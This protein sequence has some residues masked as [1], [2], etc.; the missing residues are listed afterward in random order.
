M[1]V[2]R[3]HKR[4]SSLKKKKGSR[5]LSRKRSRRVRSKSMAD[6]GRVSRKL[7]RKKTRRH[8]RRAKTYHMKGGTKQNLDFKYGLASMIIEDKSYTGDLRRPERQDSV[9][10]YYLFTNDTGST[11][12]INYDIHIISQEDCQ[13]FSILTDILHKNINMNFNAFLKNINYDDEKGFKYN[14]DNK[15]KIDKYTLKPFNVTC[16]FGG[17]NIGKLEITYKHIYKN[18]LTQPNIYKKEDVII[19][20]PR[21]TS[22]IDHDDHFKFD[23]TPYSLTKFKVE[24][25]T[26]FNYL[27]KIKNNLGVGKSNP[28]KFFDTHKIYVY[29]FNED[30]VYDS[31]Y[32]NF[33]REITG[34]VTGKAIE[35]T[36]S[37]R[38]ITKEKYKQL[39]IEEV[40]NFKKVMMFY[41][42]L[43]HFITNISNDPYN[44]LIKIDFRGES[45]RTVGF[46]TKKQ[47][48]YI[49]KVK[50]ALKDY[51][52][53]AKSI[54]LS[55]SIVIVKDD[56]DKYYIIVSNDDDKSYLELQ[57]NTNSQSLTRINY[58]YIDDKGANKSVGISGLTITYDNTEFK[59]FI[60]KTN[61]ENELNDPNGLNPT[62]GSFV[63]L[64]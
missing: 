41:T 34:S 44:N 59:I 51:L 17:A 24:K 2:T 26:I 39:N 56:T 27:N 55:E 18:K 33:D 12:N 58:N 15:T 49:V 57:I 13:Y 3:R 50:D 30:E 43:K 4:K 14:I 37:A 47:R 36:D 23:G 5:K 45:T 7:K 6:I 16:K 53:K 61:L 32:T 48:V 28:N 52:T 38:N 29:G 60:E 40:I 62:D 64:D 21:P 8:H 54:R 25:A 1:G 63:L 19:E 20:I 9:P 11:D 22:N 35:S 31:N 10:N 46:V 42:V